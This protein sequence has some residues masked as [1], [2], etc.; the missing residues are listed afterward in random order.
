[1]YTISKILVPVD[2]SEQSANGLQYAASLANKNGTEITALHVISKD[3]DDSL[4]RVLTAFE[5]WLVPPITANR[6]PLD[7]QLHERALDLY[8]FIET[9]LGKR[10][11]PQIAREVRIGDPVKEIVAV[12]RKRRANLVIME[13]PKKSPFSYLLSWGLL[14][15]LTLRL[16]CP[17]LLA[18]PNP[19][20]AGEGPRDRRLLAELT[21]SS[22]SR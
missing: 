13:R 10:F 19:A 18:P 3:K 15:R 21:A 9:V 14:L 20:N 2:F 7:Q 17:V 1:M 16:P 4:Q 12:A 22:Q 8:N 11:L 5:G 6:L